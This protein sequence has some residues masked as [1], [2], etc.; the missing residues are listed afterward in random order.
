MTTMFS[1]LEQK[2]EMMGKIHESGLESIWKIRHR[3]LDDVRA[4]RI[5][6]PDLDTDPEFLKRFQREARSTALLRHP[7]IVELYDFSI[8]P[9][10]QAFIVME[11]IDGV[12]LRTLREDQG[13]L[14]ISHI[15]E[16]ALQSLE[17]I[18]FLHDAGFVHRNISPEGIMLTQDIEGYSLV[19]LIDLG[20]V[21]SLQDGQHVTTL[22]MFLGKTRYASPEQFSESELTVW[23]DLYSFGV[24][25]YELLTGELPI[26]GEDLFSF[27]DGHLHRPPRSF[28]ETDRQGRVPDELRNLVL[29]TLAK[30]PTD[31]PQSAAQLAE[32]LRS[33]QEQRDGLG[34]KPPPEPSVSIASAVD[35][36][37][38]LETKPASPRPTEDARSDSYGPVVLP[39][40]VSPEDR[41]AAM[42]ADEVQSPE[43]P[44]LDLQE[45]AAE[46]PG[47]LDVG[48]DT[49]AIEIESTSPRPPEAAGPGPLLIGVDPEEET[50]TL[51]TGEVQPPEAPGPEV[52]LVE[53]PAAEIP[54]SLNVAD[55]TVSLET[56]APDPRPIEHA[57]P[58]PRLIEH[59]SPSPRPIEHATPPPRPPDRDLEHRTATMPAEKVRPPLKAS[60]AKPLWPWVLSAVVLIALIVNTAYRHFRLQRTVPERISQLVRPEATDD[61]TTPEVEPE[62]KPLTVE[63]E[64]G[65][66]EFEPEPKPPEV[67]P[68]PKLPEIEPEPKP[69]EVV[70][71]PAPQEWI[72]EPQPPVEIRDPDPPRSETVRDPKSGLIWLSSDNDQDIDW[73]G[74][75]AFCESYTASHNADWRLPTLSEL[76]SIYD[77]ESQN[78]MK[79]RLGIR[80]SDF[81]IWSSHSRTSD[82]AMYFVYMTGESGHVDKATSSRQRALCVS[83]G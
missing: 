5:V 41:T 74:A 81:C 49:V 77:P 25:F 7:N 55:D 14:P 73:T 36:T 12:N 59:A 33:F 20:L 47:S 44:R 13:P 53:E 31:R 29:R 9:E 69:P 11:Y 52:P 67:E 82:Q 24:V 38:T 2:Y 3:L 34:K 63:P 70:P 1:A 40:D 83:G 26:Q 51:P 21:R 43:A 50:T 39:T 57:T 45:P 6:L 54:V 28:A 22:G 76:K 19:K 80:I 15:L 78:V 35:E 18:A 72:P 75:N 42:P 37:V 61:T 48:A 30:D 10:G 66:P 8:T 58:P 23:S 79:T 4:V 27:V 32:H 64:P 71:E 46:I 65:P 68:G 17:A 16:I 62:P 60:G 56:E